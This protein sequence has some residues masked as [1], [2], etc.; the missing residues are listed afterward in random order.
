MFLRSAS[1]FC[2]SVLA[3]SFSCCA[4]RTPCFSCTDAAAIELSSTWYFAPPAPHPAAT[5]RTNGN[6]LR[7]CCLLFQAREPREE[8][9]ELLF[10]RVVDV[11]EVG[12]AIDHFPEV[13]ALD[14]QQLVADRAQPLGALVLHVVEDLARVAHARFAGDEIIGSE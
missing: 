1:A 6:A 7:M 14:A 4:A 8:N 3:T 5:T 13:L 10:A 12:A 2:C 11:V 9:L